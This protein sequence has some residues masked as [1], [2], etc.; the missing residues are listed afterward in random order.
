MR[1]TK[2][3]IALIMTLLM[4]FSSV[5][6]VAYATDKNNNDL[7]INDDDFSISGTN[8]VGNIVSELTNTDNDNNNDNNPNE[9]IELYL[10]NK[11]AYVQFATET[12]AEIFV[13]VYEEETKQMVGSGKITVYPNQ[14]EAKVNI[15]C[16]VWPEYF[17]LK[18]F[19]LDSKTSKPLCEQFTNPYYTKELEEFFSKTIYDFDEEEVI[20]LDND[21]TNNFVVLK[22]G[23][24]T[25][26]AKNGK[27]ELVDIDTDNGIITVKN[28][29]SE[30]LSLKPDG[31]LHYIYGSGENDY[32]IICVDRIENNGSIFKIYCKEAEVEELLQF[33]RIE[34][35]VT[36]SD[37]DYVE[38]E[39]FQPYQ[40]NSNLATSK[41]ARFSS[42][43]PIVSI[44]AKEAGPSFT[45][46]IGDKDG[47]ISGSLNAKISVTFKLY[48]SITVDYY[49]VFGIPTLPSDIKPYTDFEFKFTFDASFDVT[50]C[51]KIDFYEKE[52]HEITIPLVFGIDFVGT[53]KIVASF[54]GNVT[55]EFTYLKAVGTSYK[56]GEG[57]HDIDD[58]QMFYDPLLGSEVQL[59]IGVGLEMGLKALKIVKLSLAGE[60]GVKITGVPF[61]Y[62]LSKDIKHLCPVCISVDVKLYGELGLV[63]K[64]DINIKKVIEKE[65]E[66]ANVNFLEAES[67]ILEGYCS[68]ITG[69]L[70][71]YSGTCP[72]TAYR[73]T[74]YVVDSNNQPIPNAKIGSLYT[75]SQGTASDFY[76]DGNYSVNVSANNY[77]SS[78]ANFTVK[79]KPKTVTV[80]LQKDGEDPTDPVD[81]IDPPITGSI[82]WNYISTTK[83]LEI[84]GSGDMEDYQSY[85]SAPWFTYH[86]EIEKVVIYSGVTSVGDFSFAQCPKLK[87]V[88][89]PETVTD[90]G[91]GAFYSCSLLEEIVINDNIVEIGDYAYFD[92]YSAD[93]I[94]LG[95]SLQK[96]GSYAFSQCTAVTEVTIPKSV[97]SIKY[98]AFGG[99][100]AL[101]AIYFLSSNCV[102]DSASYTIPSRA[103]IYAQSGSTAEK[104]ASA[105]SRAFAIYN[106][107]KAKGFSMRS[108]TTE[109]YNSNDVDKYSANVSGTVD[110]TSYIFIVVSSDLTATTP[111]NKQLMFIDQFTADDSGEINVEFSP[112][113]SQISH[114]YFI[115]DFADGTI[116][117]EVEVTNE[118]NNCSCIC[119]KTGILNFFFRI[120][121][122]FQRIFGL[123]QICSCG[124]K[125]Y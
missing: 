77:Q 75:N 28:P 14:E 107:S 93:S 26:E 40:T 102:I 115:G 111:S 123:N 99:C 64:I 7:Q 88:T 20:N 58:S 101:N 47:I 103:T 4:L 16:D 18:A 10:E 32:E 72:N 61:S 33:V 85:G 59:K 45:F 68:N 19:M 37:K 122:F 27:N 11:V 62:Q 30:M 49:E 44:P 116:V 36:T 60:I 79:Q 70:K 48:F 89:I 74:F 124:V 92:C 80:K 117:K 67:T 41:K 15:D 5:Q 120:L 81:P 86:N 50:I 6:V 13:A 9:I 17:I 118:S 29:D 35:V 34:Q 125:H 22:D 66:L 96:I 112:K 8:P 63:A 12:Q 54:S 69:K 100:N 106:S 94:S 23:A 56:T 57:S 87:N 38:P 82:T 73:V 1:T 31:V 97:T 55:L 65:I 2:R 90:I 78:S 104:Y 98:G 76:I 109:S 83:T 24:I 43:H 121:L 113:N 46:N 119:H 53:P 25:V 108:Y 52:L 3:V 39:E 42:Y 84:K 51:G 91:K 21:E 110:G 105:N 71:W 95:K 114:A